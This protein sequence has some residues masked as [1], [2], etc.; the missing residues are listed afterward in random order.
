[1]E[2]EIALILARLIEISRSGCDLYERTPPSGSGFQN[3]VFTEPRLTFDKGRPTAEIYQ[4]ASD[5]LRII[6]KHT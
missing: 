5:L 6:Q 4:T 1:M 3:Q 2:K